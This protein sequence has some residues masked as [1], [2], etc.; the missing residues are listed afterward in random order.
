MDDMFTGSLP[1]FPTTSTAFQSL[2][3]LLS[4]IPQS[5]MVFNSPIKEVSGEYTHLS[6]TSGTGPNTSTPAD[7]LDQTGEH[8]RTGDQSRSHSR[9][10]AP[11]ITP[12]SSPS[13]QGHRTVEEN[14]TKQCYPEINE[15]ECGST[16]QTD[17][18]VKD[19]ASPVKST[20]PVPLEQRQL[21][22]SDVHTKKIMPQ[23]FFA[24]NNPDLFETSNLTDEDDPN[25][26]IIKIFPVPLEQMKISPDVHSEN[27]SNPVKVISGK[28]SEVESV[29]VETNI[30]IDDS[31]DSIN[32][33]DAVKPSPNISMD[34]ISNPEK[35]QLFS[36]QSG[37]LPSKLSPSKLVNSNIDPMSNPNPL[38]SSPP[39][40]SSLSRVQEYLQSLPSPA[41]RSRDFMP[42]TPNCKFAPCDES[43]NTQSQDEVSSI[44]SDSQSRRSDLSSLTGSRAGRGLLHGSAIA[45]GST[46]S[47]CPFPED[48]QFN[49]IPES[50]ENDEDID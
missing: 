22:S 40:H 32:P 18:A 39:K 24:E 19:V 26:D 35:D 1:G 9:A 31:D 47:V 7:D 45:G 29:T 34:E 20:T 28:E 10:D 2:E 44:C 43:M 42:E 50:I 12:Q 15:E 25:Q 46:V 27:D 16:N 33:S 23:P 3:R 49:T 14:V 17:L 5:Q 38:F 41:S 48:W 37:S 6:T 30:D 13:L 8:S 36:L 21:N 11:N 4:S